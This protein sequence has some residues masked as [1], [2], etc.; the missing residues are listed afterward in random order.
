MCVVK[1]DPKRPDKKIIESAASV[2]KKGGLVVFPTETVYGIAANL[3]D[4]GAID[5]LYRIK[6]RPLNKPFTVHISDLKVIKD[7]GCTVT[8]QARRLIDKFWPGPLTI[9][10]KSKDKRSIGF[11]MPSN[12]VAL[13]LIKTSGVPIA[14]PSANL[15]GGR[16]PIS[17]EEALK[18]LGGEVDMVLDAGATDVGI[19]SSVIDL[20]VEP[21]RVLREGAIKSR[22]LS[23]IM[24]ND[25]ILPPRR[26]PD[27]TG[28]R[29]NY[30]GLRN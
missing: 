5:K 4:R 22:E 20:T 26:D 15:S 24:T 27:K 18:D 23:K 28:K 16:P 25:K 17:A 13:D 21:P 19:E 8:K 12:R 29:P 14:A 3:L 30:R 2:I 6:S 11:R 7:M 1:I 9:I 10:L